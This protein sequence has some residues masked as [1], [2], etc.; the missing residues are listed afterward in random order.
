MAAVPADPGSFDDRARTWDDAPHRVERARAAA[1]MIAQRVPL[2]PA[3]RLLDYGAGTG[4]LAQHLAPQVGEVALV[5][6]SEGMREVL[7]AKIAAGVLPADASVLD[8]DLGVAEPPDGLA[9]DL[10]VSLMVVHHILD[11]PAA[12]RRIRS[13]LPRG[14]HLCIVDLEEEDGSYHSPSFRGHPGIRREA[15][16]R[17]LEASGFVP[18][19]FEPA[20]TIEKHGRAYGLFLAVARAV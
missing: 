2:G 9:C 13:L 16:A 14:G 11:I 12:L 7:H 8:I 3:T 19:T 15:L 5:E 17:D 20:F 6:P 4:L 10:V 18:P 1:G